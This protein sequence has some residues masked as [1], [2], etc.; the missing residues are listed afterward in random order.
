MTLAPGTRFGPYEIQQQIGE[1]GMGSVYRAQ[2]T[3]LNRLVAIKM[4]AAH[5][6]DCFRQEALA[7]A[8]LSHPHICV[9]HDV[10]PDYLVM[11]YLD[12]AA[13]QG[14]MPFED[15]LRLGS[16]WRAPLRGRTRKGS[17]TAI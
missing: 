15:V 11:E 12:G 2:D 1:G 14:P 8:A 17:S 9:L 4:L 6:G 3:R 16:R 13:P 5:C 7:I 10:G